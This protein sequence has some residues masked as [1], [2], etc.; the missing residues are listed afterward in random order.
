MQGSR[1]S[2]TLIERTAPTGR[3]HSSILCASQMKRII[4]LVLAKLGY[5]VVRIEDASTANEGLRPFFVL[6]KRF[7]FAPKHI[8]DI[9]ANHGR[10]TREAIKF[11][12]DARYTLVEPQDNLKTYIQDL[13]E[14]GCKIQWINAG[15]SDRSGT[16]RFTI[17]NRDDSS[18]FVLTAAQARAGGLQQTTVPVKTV[19]EIAASAGGD[20]P[21]MVKIDAEGLDLKVLA[22]ASEL[23]GKTDVFLVEAMVCA[24]YE[25]SAAEVIKFMAGAGY[26]LVDVT[27]LNRSPKHGVLWACELA[28][29][30]NGCPLFDAATNYE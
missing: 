20:L 9:G 7:G 23:T 14:L 15:A 3:R 25:N 30:R 27:D 2:A 6:L 13:L 8:L 16:L 24:G 19:N 28:F 10:W 29:L 18:T 5:R 11:F 1:T 4:H 21:D 17:A 12:P 22:G 26:R